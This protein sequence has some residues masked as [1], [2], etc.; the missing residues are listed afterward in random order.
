MKHRQGQLLDANGGTN[1]R[2]TTANFG[3]Q[4][5]PAAWGEIGSCGQFCF[6]CGSEAVIK[7]E[8]FLDGAVD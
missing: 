8:N 1:R 2:N 5:C 4:N 3:Y 7:K 6:H